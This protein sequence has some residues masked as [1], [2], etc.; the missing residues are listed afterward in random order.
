MVDR[1]VV[2][3]LLVSPTLCLHQIYPMLC[4]NLPLC[5]CLESGLASS[6]FSESLEAGAS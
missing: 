5:S 1:G 2:P 6:H 3:P 4:S